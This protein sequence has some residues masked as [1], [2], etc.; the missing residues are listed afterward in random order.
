MNNVLTLLNDKNDH[1]HKFLL[2]NEA[3]LANF[4]HGNFD[5]LEIFYQSRETILDLIR[6]IDGLVDVA[7]KSS[8]V[9]AA[10]VGPEYKKQILT[11]LNRKND[12]VHEILS[13]DL[14][15][16]S[17]IETAKSDIIKDLKQVQ[18]ARKAV[19]A[20]KSGDAKNQLDE[21]A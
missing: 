20:Y 19:G 9:D 1:L 15:I 7:L 16:L 5:N 2:I 6:C 13:Q 12:L 18:A 21:E 14:Q 10:T 4:S 17:V 11:M 3:E 8:P